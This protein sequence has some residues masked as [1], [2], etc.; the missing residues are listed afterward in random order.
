MAQDDPQPAPAEDEYVPVKIP[1]VVF[2]GAGIY[3]SWD[4]SGGHP[5]YA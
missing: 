5:T 3:R 4:L 2:H 1:D